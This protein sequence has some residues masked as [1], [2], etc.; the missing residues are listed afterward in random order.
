MNPL[1]TAAL[2]AISNRLLV[3]VL[4]LLCISRA[5]AATGAAV[6]ATGET[7]RLQQPATRIISL[8][9]HATELLFAAGAGNRVVGT[10]RYS[11]YPQAA[12]AIPRVG[13]AHNVDMERLLSLQPDLIVA[14]QSGNPAGQ[15]R[16]LRELN[17]PVYL[18]EP[19]TLED[20][21]ATIEALGTL[22]GTS[23]T[24]AKA[25]RDFRRQLAGLRQQYANRNTVSVFYQIWH[26]PLITIGAGHII[27][28]AIQLCGGRN[29]FGNVGQLA[30]RVSVE[31]VLAAAPEVV[32]AS[33]TDKKRPEWLDEWRQWPRLPAVK[34][35]QLHFIPP[36]YLQR[37]GPRLLK[38]TDRLCEILEQARANSDR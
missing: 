25:A 35:N 27:N 30:P 5:I 29:V 33:G 31:A 22:A 21:A 4:G 16:Q 24:A 13:D 34:H 7:V 18:S 37:A 10:V 12:R 8:A 2:A 23:A 28:E 36:A 11:D 9:P 19:R 32:I 20:V 38:G 3:L 15:L 14:W 17:L 1:T 6:D 26:E